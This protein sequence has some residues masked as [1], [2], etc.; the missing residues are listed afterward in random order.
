MY[1]ILSKHFDNKLSSLAQQRPYAAGA[2]KFRVAQDDK[3]EYTK[4][5]MNNINIHAQYITDF[6]LIYEKD[7]EERLFAIAFLHTSKTKES[8]Q[9]SDHTNY[10]FKTGTQ[11]IT[12]LKKAID[13]PYEF[14]V[15]NKSE[16]YFKKPDVKKFIE[17]LDEHKLHFKEVLKELQDL[18]ISVREAKTPEEMDMTALNRLKKKYGTVYKNDKI[19]TFR[20]Q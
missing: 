6:N 3:K 14:H 20:I 8:H 7:G 19:E 12:F 18:N 4:E 10:S 1:K 5:E 9:I 2:G 11:N 13:V 17:G 15:F 16:E